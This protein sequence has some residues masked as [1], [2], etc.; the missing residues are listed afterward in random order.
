VA[1][2]KEDPHRLF[3]PEGTIF[4]PSECGFVLPDG[5]YLRVYAYG[6]RQEL[7]DGRAASGQSHLERPQLFAHRC[8]YG[9]NTHSFGPSDAASYTSATAVEFVLPDTLSDMDDDG[10]IELTHLMMRTLIEL[11]MTFDLDDGDLIAEFADGEPY[12]HHIDLTTAGPYDGK[13]MP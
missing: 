10:L 1:N 5:R 2:I 9:G 11:E 4:Y 3:L 12:A 6:V 8:R 13:P 7:P